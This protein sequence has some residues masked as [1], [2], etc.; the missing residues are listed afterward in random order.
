MR[1]GDSPLSS[2]MPRRETSSEVVSHILFPL[3]TIITEPLRAEASEGQ[4]V[5]V[6][7]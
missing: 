6:D 7:L 1:G 2:S 4:I 3:L 5:L